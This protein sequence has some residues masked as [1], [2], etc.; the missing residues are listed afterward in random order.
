LHAFEQTLTAKT[1][2]SHALGLT[3]GW[4]SEPTTLVLPPGEATTGATKQ[5]AA[6]AVY[7]MV[8]GWESKE[9]HLRATET[10]AFRAVAGPVLE[11]MLPFADGLEVRHVVFTSLPGKQ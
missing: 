7:C 10:D 4:A 8:V 5:S 6:A 11:K 3:S 2:P 1:T 9:A